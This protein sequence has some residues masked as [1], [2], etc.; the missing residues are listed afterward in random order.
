VL[1]PPAVS[2]VRMPRLTRFVDVTAGRI[3]RSFSQLRPL[4]GGQLRL[5]A[6]EQPVDDLAL[7]FVDRLAGMRFPKL[8]FLKHIPQQ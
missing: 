5:E 3:L 8:G 7:T 4:R 2:L 1:R 6:I